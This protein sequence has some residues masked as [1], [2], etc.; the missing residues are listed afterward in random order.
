MKKEPTTM[1]GHDLE[2]LRDRFWQA[3]EET[4]WQPFLEDDY[5]DFKQIFGRRDKPEAGSFT[6]MALVAFCPERDFTRLAVRFRFFAD[7]RLRREREFA[8][9]PASAEELFA[10]LR[11]SCS[12]MLRQAGLKA[13]MEDELRMDRAR[14]FSSP[15]KVDFGRE[16]HLK[17]SC[18]LEAGYLFD[19][20][21]K[22]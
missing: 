12:R 21:V 16:R 10:G 5:S 3:M 8:F 11:G 13:G 20:R 22:K 1:A 18:I 17:P 2:S 6:R 7:P 19:D 14:R 15:W 9:D 4:G